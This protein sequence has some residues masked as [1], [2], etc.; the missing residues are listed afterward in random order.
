MAYEKYPLLQRALV[1]WCV[2]MW[3][4]YADGESVQVSGLEFMADIECEEDLMWPASVPINPHI[5]GT[6]SFYI[7]Q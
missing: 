1:S 2:L 5:R 7:S 4:E 3:E 6:V